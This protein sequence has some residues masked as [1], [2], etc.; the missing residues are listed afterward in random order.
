MSKRP[1]D[2]ELPEQPPIKMVRMNVIDFIRFTDPDFAFG[3]K[4]SEAPTEFPQWSQLMP[5]LQ[6]M[7]CAFLPT[8]RALSWTCTAER[9]NF[10]RALIDA[11]NVAC[12]ECHRVEKARDLTMSGYCYACMWHE[13]EVGPGFIGTPYDCR[14][15]GAHYEGEKGKLSTCEPCWKL[16]NKT[17]FAMYPRS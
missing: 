11:G 2:E 14:G 10:G 3:A 17:W 12:I 1:A 7:V 13:K 15:C 8:R 6:A 4:A 16:I 9:D 5:E